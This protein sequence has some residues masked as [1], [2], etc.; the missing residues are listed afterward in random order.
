MSTK[1]SCESVSTDVLKKDRGHAKAN[2]TR[3]MNQVETLLEGSD[4]PQVTKLM[5]G[6]NQALDVFETKQTEYHIKLT[7]PAEQE[8]SSEYF[9][10]FTAGVQLFKEKVSGWLDSKTNQVE[11]NQSLSQNIEHHSV[12]EAGSVSSSILQLQRE[13]YE[14]KFEALKIKGELERQRDEIELRRKEI[15]MEA[16]EQERQR[17][18]HFRLKEIELE[19]QRLYLERQQ[20]EIQVEQGRAVKGLD[21]AS[22][23][24]MHTSTPKQSTLHGRQVESEAGKSPQLSSVKPRPSLDPQSN[25]D[26]G[27]VLCRMLNDSQ[28]QQQTL[29]QAIQLPKTELMIYDGN[30]L[31][32]TSF[33]T[34]FENSVHHESVP[35]GAKLDWLIQ[36][37]TGRVKKL[38]QCCL[39]KTPT[40][41]YILARKLL[42]ERFGNPDHITRAWIDKILNRPKVFGSSQLLEYADDLRCAMETLTT[43]KALAEISSQDKLYAIAEKLPDY[44]ARR[45]LKKVHKIKKERAATIEDLVQ[46]IT[47]EAEEAADPVFGKLAQGKRNQNSENMSRRGK[48]AYSSQTSALDSERATTTSKS[49]SAKSV[50]TQPPNMV[51]SCPC[52]K[53]NHFITRCE[54]FRAMKVKDRVSF[55]QSKHLCFLCLKPNHNSR[56]CTRTFVCD[57]NGCGKKH[58]RFLHLPRSGDDSQEPSAALNDG[59]TQVKTTTSVNCNY[60]KLNSGKIAL[61]I[62][63]VRVRGKGRRNYIDTYALCDSGSNQTYVSRHLADSLSLS[64]KA[65]VIDEATISGTQT[66]EVQLSDILLSNTEDSCTFE[67]SDVII[68]PSLNIGLMSRVSQDELSNWQHLK[69][70]NVP[71]VQADDVHILIGQDLLTC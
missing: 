56:E 2:V 69:D 45:W 23:P 21:A 13:A 64:R 48:K 15:E 3:V 52:C 43:T 42:R 49:K 22:D 1:E 67:A 35:D 54:R 44:L 32:Y 53:E 29:V 9:R 65:M 26:V 28:I 51:Y 50:N 25:M 40:E 24:S 27:E 8:D 6:F 66:I 59:N 36:Y 62:M 57:I 4:V 31:E 39:S 37:T 38:L 63:A 14:Q 16:A 12:S 30:P 61:P 10:K 19:R 41:G 18:Y 58:N 46:F 55:V 68:K 71:D 60:S 33:I 17:E 11:S 5:T 34:S 20:N 70:I 7:S 47:D